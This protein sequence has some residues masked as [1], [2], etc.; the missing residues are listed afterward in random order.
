MTNA[1]AKLPKN[2]ALHLK[3]RYR[4]EVVAK[5]EEMYGILFTAEVPVTNEQ[6]RQKMGLDDN[7]HLYREAK[8]A[9]VWAPKSTVYV[10][11][12]GI[13]LHKFATKDHQYWHLAW[14]LGLFEI[15]SLQLEMDEDLLAQAPRAIHELIARGKYND[16]EGRRLRQLSNRAIEASGFLLR[17]ARMYQQMHRALN[18]Y[19]LPEIKGTDLKTTMKQIKKLMDKS[20]Y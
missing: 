5:V 4:A 15:S 11:Q 12:D 10:T 8:K 1:L 17:L 14:S 16:T 18:L 6:L 2:L 7:P 20:S 13:V 3:S 19:L 9:L